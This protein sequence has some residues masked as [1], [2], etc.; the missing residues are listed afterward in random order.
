MAKRPAAP[1]SGGS[2][3]DRVDQ[4]ILSELERDGRASFA[5]LAERVG[6]SKSPCWSRV[7]AL[8]SDG[9]ITGYRALV[10]PPSVGLTTSAFV[11]V[12]VGFAHHSAFEQAVMRHPKVLSCHAT[13]GETDYLLHVLAMD[14]AALDDFLRQEL[15]RL[16]GVERFV[17][18][19]AM[20]AIKTDGLVTANLPA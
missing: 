13:I 1:R 5:D 2:T 20:R 10:D 18:M 14:M 15:W 11:R 7:Q 6:L 4:A 8:E 3:R 16:P 9:V 12:V 17:T 19:I